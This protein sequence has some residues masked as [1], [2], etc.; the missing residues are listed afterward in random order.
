MEL[1]PLPRVLWNSHHFD[2]YESILDSIFAISSVFLRYVFL[3]MYH[4]RQ[5]EIV[6]QSYDPEK[7]MYQFT[8]TG[9]IFRRFIS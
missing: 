2:K 5:T 4:V 6:C 9:P 8:P 1:T 3:T 7:L